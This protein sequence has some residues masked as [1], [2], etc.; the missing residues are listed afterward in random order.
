[1]VTIQ[2][3]YASNP[4]GETDTLPLFGPFRY[5]HMVESHHTAGLWTPNHG[6]CIA[7]QMPGGNWLAPNNEE[8]SE[9]IIRCAPILPLDGRVPLIIEGSVFVDDNGDNKARRSR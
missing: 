6:E 8:Y 1:M 3:V 4:R 2:F 5:L 9:F 7:Q